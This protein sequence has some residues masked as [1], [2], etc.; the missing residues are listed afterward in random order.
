M[1]KQTNNG[2]FLWGLF[3]AVAFMGNAQDLKQTVKGKVTDIATGSPLMGATIILV[4]SEPQIGVITDAQGF[5]S[6]ENVPVGRQSFSCGYLGY[7]DA[8]ISEVFGG[9]CK[10]NQFEYK[11]YRI[12]K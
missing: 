11:T 10:R 12:L 8:S 4:G 7:E 2:A 6:M 3:L 1:R 5:F 9:V